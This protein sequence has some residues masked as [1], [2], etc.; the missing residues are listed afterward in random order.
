MA[1]PEGKIIGEQFAKA[2]GYKLGKT[3][4]IAS[5]AGYKDWFIQDYRR[6]GYTVEVG[7]GKTPLPLTQFDQIYNDN[8]ELLLLASII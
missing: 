4:G 6:P 1:P 5:Y 7:L 3:T 2:S 8:L